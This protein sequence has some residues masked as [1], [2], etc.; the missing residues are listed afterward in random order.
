MLNC[1]CVCVRWAD[2]S[3]PGWGRGHQKAPS[4]SVVKLCPMFAR[5]KVL[6]FMLPLYCLI[7]VVNR[8]RAPAHCSKCSLRG[9]GWVFCCCGSG[10]GYPPCV[11][12]SWCENSSLFLRTFSSPHFSVVWWER[13]LIMFVM[14]MCGCVSVYVCVCQTFELVGHLYAIHKHRWS[15]VTPWEWIWSVRIDCVFPLQTNSSR[16]F[17]M[18]SWLVSS[19]ECFFF[20]AR[21]VEWLSVIRIESFKSAFRSEICIYKI[22]IISKGMVKLKK[23]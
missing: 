16:P 3:D 21:A 13:F 8:F 10:R 11:L 9:W 15:F 17:A 7:P 19:I 4:R 6:R 23:T 20:I 22:M 1:V 12:G 14:C 5:I 18:P 2:H